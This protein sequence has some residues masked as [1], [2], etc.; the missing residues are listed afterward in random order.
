MDFL[1]RLKEV[2]NANIVLNAPLKIGMLEPK[3]SA[4]AMRTV[5]SGIKTK[6]LNGDTVYH[7]AVQFLIQD[8]DQRLVVNLLDELTQFMDRLKK[9]SIVSQDGSFIFNAASV[10]VLPNFVQ[11]SANDEYVY[12][13]IYVSEIETKGV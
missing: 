2:I 11:K 13:A 7:V 9:D 10:S 6:Y 12:T 4:A 1:D 8:A 5:S 3:G